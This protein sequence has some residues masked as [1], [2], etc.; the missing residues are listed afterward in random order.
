[1][2]LLGPRLSLAHGVWLDEREIAALADAGVSVVLNPISN[3][4]NKNGVAPI[5]RLAA[6]GVNLALGCDNCS[7]TDAQN[8]FQAMKMFTLLAAVSDPEIGP[9][10]ALDA[11]RAATFGGARTAGLEREIGGIRAGMKADLAV[12]DL[13]DPA[14]VPLNSLA[15]QL[16]YSE[17]GRGV[18][19]VIVDGRFVMENR[20]IETIDDAALRDEAEAIM[21][22][23]RPEAEAVFARNRRL[24]Q[25]LLEADARVWSTDIGMNR[26]VGDR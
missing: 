7:C 19:S 24:S 10:D 2:G 9:P 16:V 21:R 1:A 20:K 22:R 13:D 26:Y 14:F 12:L 17:C 4:K 8:I 11:I 25:Y 23:F 18:D 3:L 6:A 5:R 15:R